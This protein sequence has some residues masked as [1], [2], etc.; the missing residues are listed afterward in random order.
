MDSEFLAGLGGDPDEGDSA[1]VH[2]AAAPPPPDGDV[3]GNL[4]IVEN[5]RIWDLGPADV[6]TDADGVA[7]SL[8]RPGPN[9][10]TV[11]TDSDRDGQVDLI[12]EVH[13]DGGFSSARLDRASGEWVAT[14][15][16]RLE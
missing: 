14:D 9:G 8:T 16:G 10:L 7:D 15:S 3:Y 2:H 13:R 5:D 11:Y 12:T 1:F 4:W 6:D